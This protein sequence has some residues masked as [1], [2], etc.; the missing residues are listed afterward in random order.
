MQKK[1]RKFGWHRKNGVTEEILKS[2]LMD[3]DCNSNRLNSFWDFFICFK[4][5]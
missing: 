5:F 1:I 4:N 3:L 2:V